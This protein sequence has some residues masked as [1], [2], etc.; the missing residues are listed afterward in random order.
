MF[1]KDSR[2]CFIGDS[3]THAGFQIRRIYEYLRK[4]QKLPLKIFNCGVS[5]DNATNGL[6]RLEE[7]VFIHNPTDVVIAYG[8]NDI[9]IH[10]Y[11]TDF[12]DERI[13]NER[14]MRIDNCVFNIGSIACRCL[15]KG[16]NV[17]FCTP[18]TFDELQSESYSRNL[19]SMGALLEVSARI[20]EKAKSLGCKIVDYNKESLKLGAKLFKTNETIFRD[21]RVHPTEEGYEFMAKVFLNNLGY[22]VSIPET[23]EEL[24]ALKDL[25]HDNWETERFEM[26]K[27]ALCNVFVRYCLFSNIHEESLIPAFC[28]K[29]LE[30]ETWDVIINELKA[31]DKNRTVAPV[32][33][34]K[35]YKFTEQVE[36]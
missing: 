3:I 9:G 16:I 27:K 8:V 33:R 20:R 6:L 11:D 13:V 2:I 25:P 32:Y 28:K 35:L 29:K 10:L 19:G 30:T 7:T 14:R 23:L 24:K 22:E 4:E 1:N 21:D 26:E 18:M 34:E 31:Y 12:I 36:I 5:G 17:I 15:E